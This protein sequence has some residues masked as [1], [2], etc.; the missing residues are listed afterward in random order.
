MADDYQPRGIFIGRTTEQLN[1]LIA[2]ADDAILNGRVTAS[3]GIGLSS[4]IEYPMTPD[5]IL[6]EAR[7]AL[8]IASGTRRPSR[9]YS[10]MRNA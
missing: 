8:D 5:V 1:T 4:T 10:D 9:I 7:F 6:I 2:N 3:S